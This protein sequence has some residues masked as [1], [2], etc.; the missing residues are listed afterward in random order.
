MIHKHFKYYTSHI[1]G[2]VPAGIVVFLVAL[3][4]CLGIALA[5]GAPLFSGLIAGLVGGLVVAWF[6]GSQLSVSGPAAGLTVIVLN[7]IEKIGSFQ[8][9]LTALV[10]AGF[11]Q[12]VFGFLRAGI[13]AAFFPSSVIEGMLAAIGLILIIKQFPHAAGYDANF[14][15]D[16]SYMAD[17]AGSS[18]YA[19]VDAMKAI[20]PGA[21]VISSVALLILVIWELPWFK[22]RKLFSLIPGPLIAV[23]WGVAYNLT[24]MKF[25]PEWA[26]SAKHMV[27]L[28]VLDHPTALFDQFIFPDWSFLANPQIYTVAV[29]I[30]IIASLET[31]LSLEAVDKLDPLKRIAPT[32]REL[33]AQGIGNMISGMLGGLPITAVIVRSSANINAGGR[34]RVS[35]F[36]H[37]VCLLISLLFFTQYLNYIPLAC[38]A[39]ILLQTGYKLAKP[40]LFKE[41]YRKGFSQFLPFVVTVGAILA[42][43]LLLGMAI[44]MAIGMFFVIKANYHA[45]ITMTQD[46]S[47]YVISL[48]KDVSFLNKA[49]LRKFF[50]KIEENSTVLIDASRA[51]FIDHDILE[52]IEDF[53]A[54]APDDNIK[55][56]V[57]DLYGKETIK[58]HEAMIVLNGRSN[59]PQS[60]T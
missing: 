12:L 56:K 24:A 60:V 51:Q 19:M 41:Y 37:G 58:K 23:A 9:F 4:L 27:T 49:L 40:K 45:A 43:D 32:N 30:T 36:V 15:G 26:V 17:T 2:D 25:A 48:N 44:G 52:T 10:I 50:L 53:L 29:T 7:A 57:V 14:E 54:A 42:T 6:S 16:E 11:L 1:K 21:V 20:S 5:S 22:K 13:I 3:P 46:D 31:L 47:H 55:V 38:L 59:K 8:G 28:P 18:M 34:T 33:K 39:A 35:C